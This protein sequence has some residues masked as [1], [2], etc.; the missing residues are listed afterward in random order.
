MNALDQV[1]EDCAT[2]IMKEIESTSESVH[3]KQQHRIESKKNTFRKIVEFHIESNKKIEEDPENVRVKV[4]SLI[5]M[6]MN[7]SLE[8]IFEKTKKGLARNNKIA[9][10]N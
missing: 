3:Q 10:I 8:L 7:P 9:R 6:F 4:E 1:Y 2:D 5:K